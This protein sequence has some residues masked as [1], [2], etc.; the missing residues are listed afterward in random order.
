MYWVLFDYSQLKLE[1]SDRKEVLW[2]VEMSLVAS[3]CHLFHVKLFQFKTLWEP[4]EFYFGERRLRLGWYISYLNPRLKK[5]DLVVE[6]VFEET[7]EWTLGQTY[8]ILEKA[9]IPV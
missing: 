9:S 6:F 7:D 2:H 5:K 8:Q 4:F 3:P 1:D